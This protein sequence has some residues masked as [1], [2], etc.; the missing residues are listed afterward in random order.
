MAIFP[1]VQR[2]AQQEIDQVIGCGRL[3]TITDRENLPY[4]E[5]VVKEVMRW[6]S[7]VPMGL[8]HC[9]TEDDV[10][11][12]YFIP[13]DAM[14]FANIWSAQSIPSGKSRQKKVET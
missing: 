12:G 8:P 1:D 10:Y 13:K 5:A 14:L 7:I 2:K 6:H 11:G 9:S 3:P 4:V